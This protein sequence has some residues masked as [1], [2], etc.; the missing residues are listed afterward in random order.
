[1]WRGDLDQESHSAPSPAGVLGKASESPLKGRALSWFA[2]VAPE[3]GLLA[4]VLVL[5]PS[6]CRPAAKLSSLNHIADD[7]LT[8]QN[9][10]TAPCPAPK[11]NESFGDGW[12]GLPGSSLTNLPALLPAACSHSYHIGLLGVPATGHTP[13]RASISPL[14][15]LVH[16][17]PYLCLAFSPPA[18]KFCTHAT[19]SRMSVPISP[20]LPYLPT[21][22]LPS[23]SFSPCFVYVFSL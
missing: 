5:L 3:T 14:P 2:T 17:S 7:V 6:V 23:L 13:L 15:C 19:F 1:M 12:H 18:F 21:L 20:D 9:T 22:L 10:P 4:F 16:P 11:Q 8:T